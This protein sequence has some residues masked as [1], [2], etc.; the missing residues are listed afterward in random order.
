MRIDG[1]VTKWNDD[2]GF[3]FITP[4]QGGVEVFFHMSAFPRDGQ[5]PRVGERVTFEVMVDAQGR[6]QA[7][8]VLRPGAV[9]RPRPRDRSAARN[10]CSDGLFSLIF[11]ALFL[12]S[13][14]L[15]V[16]AGKLPFAVLAL[17]LGASVVTF[18]A[19][20]LDKSAAQNDQW[21][22]KESTL[23]IFSLIGGWPGALIA[24]KSLRHKSR[25]Q[26]FQVV[27]WATVFLNCG[28]LFWLLTPTGSAFLRS[29]LA[30]MPTEG[31][32]L[33]RLV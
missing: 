8:N 30:W 25:K 10:S 7:R 6:K 12:V 14:P 21:R 19:Y 29:V 18:V 23:Q 9:I 1:T 16:W 33:S 27:F 32:T 28:A 22:T 17:Y 24:Q 11:V 3:G 26:S 2:R 13:L 15:S 4:A 5:R 31:S 20:A